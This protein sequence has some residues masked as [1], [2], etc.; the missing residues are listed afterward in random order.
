MPKSSE[1]KANYCLSWY[2]DPEKW[3]KH[4]VLLEKKDPKTFREWGTN[5][6][7]VCVKLFA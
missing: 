1:I 6:K 7:P 5:Y 4:L 3:L 2:S